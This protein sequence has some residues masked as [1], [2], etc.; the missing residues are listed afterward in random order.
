MHGWRQ[1]FKENVSPGVSVALD[2]E[3][4]IVFSVKCKYCCQQIPITGYKLR[5]SDVDCCMTTLV[6]Y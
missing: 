3:S 4:R 2:V 1:A 6:N 5:S